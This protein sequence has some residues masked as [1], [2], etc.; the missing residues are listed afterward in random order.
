MPKGL[1]E[2]I[3]VAVPHLIHVQHP[4]QQTY[5]MPCSSLTQKLPAGACEECD[6][7][8]A[9]VCAWGSRTIGTVVH[10]M[11]CSFVLRQSIEPVMLGMP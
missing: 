11:L 1:L 3:H 4:Q 5:K 9:S 6:N 10:N 8:H 2:R 7:H